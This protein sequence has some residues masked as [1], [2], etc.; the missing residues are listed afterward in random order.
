VTGPPFVPWP[1]GLVLVLASHSPRRAELL[2]SAGIPF[3][4]EPC[5]VPEATLAAAL[6]PQDGIGPAG[7]VTDPIRYA[8]GLAAAKAGATLRR[9]PDRLVLGA[10]TV[11][12]IDDAVLEKPA[13][14]E[15]A[16]ALLLRL[17]GRRHTVVSA[18]ALSG[19]PAMRPWVGHEET[20]VE[21]LPLEEEAIRRY[22]ATGEPMD[23]AG[24]YGI[25][26]YGAM[27]VRG[28]AGC[29]FNVMGLPLALL[30]RALREIL[31]RPEGR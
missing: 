5:R 12:V 20:V 26:G 25:Q 8:R 28:I 27:M 16:V 21:F 18:I 11:V 31:P 1:S 17:S 7:T 15:E 10:D 6:T 9:L 30:G 13:D 4:V 24:A 22:V 29:Y 19:P 23:K 3:A 2:R 14:A